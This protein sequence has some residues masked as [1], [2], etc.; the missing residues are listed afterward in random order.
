MRAGVQNSC[1]R[2]S[3]IGFSSLRRKRGA[4]RGV[5]QGGG[6]AV[7]A[8]VRN[9][10]AERLESRER[11]C[12]RTGSSAV[13]T[14]KRVAFR[15]S[16]LAKETARLVAGSGERVGAFVIRVVQLVVRRADAGADGGEAIV[17]EIHVRD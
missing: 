16:G 10:N 17:S 15:V 14:N 13:G 9:L 1:Y 6:P 4:T 5:M 7:A 2:A 11:D 8:G 3:R 12:S